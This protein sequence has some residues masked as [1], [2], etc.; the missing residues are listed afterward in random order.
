MTT[1]TPLPG[2]RAGLSTLALAVLAGCSFVPK[3]ERPAA[4]VTAT[5]PDS[6]GAQEVGGIAAADLPWQQFVHDAQLR[7]LIAMAIEN[8]RDLRVAV[9]NIEQARAQYQ[10]RSADQFPTVGASASGTR[11]APNPMPRGLSASVPSSTPHSP[12]APSAHPSPAHTT[13][14]SGTAPRSPCCDRSA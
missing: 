1:S 11:S 9:Q 7:E 12:P 14:R 2:L 13:G 3:Y 8:N 6:A 10:I 5:W 4:P